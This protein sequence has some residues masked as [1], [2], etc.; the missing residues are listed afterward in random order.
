MRKYLS[1]LPLSSLLLFLFPAS[2]WAYSGGDTGSIMTRSSL[3]VVQLGIIIFAA[4]IGGR[5][6]NKM[7]MPPVLGEVIA[8]VVIGPYFLGSLR[9]PHFP[10]GFFPFFGTFPV[11]PEL[12]GLAMI[13]SIVLLFLVGL[14]TDVELLFRFSTAGIAIGIGGVI[15]SFGA[16]AFAGAFF[17]SRFYGQAFSLSDPGPLFLGVISTATSVGITARV[18]LKR[19]KMDTPEGVTTLSAAVVDD[20]LG[21]IAFAV[22][23][24]I[25]RSGR[26]VWHDIIIISMKAVGI[27]LGFTVIGLVFSRNIGNFLKQFKDRPTMAVMSFSMALLLAGVFEKSGLAMI[28]GAYVMGMSLSK[29]DIS[30][31]IQEN[32]AVISKFFVPVFFCVMGM[33]I[34]LREMTHPHLILFGL[35]Y[36]IMA[37]LGKIAGCGIPSLFMNFNLRGAARIGVGMVP[38]GEVALIISGVGLALGLISHDIFSLAVIMTFLTTLSA[39]PIL[40]IMLKSDKTSLRKP[41]P[42]KKA[43]ET[44]RYP[45]PNPETTE[46]LLGKILCDFENEGFFVH[47]VSAPENLFQIRKDDVFIV[48]RKHPEELIFECSGDDSSFVHTVFYEVIAELEELMKRL[49]TVSGKKMISRDIFNN[50]S[51]KSKGRLKIY[52][53]ISPGSVSVN[54]RGWDKKEIITE[55][56]DLLISSGNLASE[57]RDDVLADLAE[58]ESAMSTGM[59]DGIA[60][61][62][63][64]TFAVKHLISAIGVKPEGIDFDSLDG[65]SSNIFVLTLAP[66]H[67]Q[68][69]YLQ[70]VGEV[71]RILINPFVR[72]RILSAKNTA[73]LYSVLVSS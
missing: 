73:E 50:V 41:S 59:Q 64:K 8:G 61:P 46:L 32:L 44:I 1:I 21:I 2:A 17:M 20:V 31:T 23:L 14:E 37:V 34:N 33:L 30:F 65:K 24:G 57:K 38:R 58:R 16:G 12:Y 18:L 3:L 22:V 52:E 42:A 72:D 6:F 15:A 10:E 28:I 29:T 13:A 9:M 43:L 62:H 67:N 27:W 11:S 25:V 47:R 35:F 54:L 19:K 55:L 51:A 60:L 63:T 70:F 45:L 5:A 69:P 48:L 66:K 71:T 49:E 39:P 68:E 53:V 26:V 56:V 40:D 36:T 7:R 4:W